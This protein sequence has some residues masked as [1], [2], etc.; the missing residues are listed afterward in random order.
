MSIRSSYLNNT[1]KPLIFSP[2]VCNF[3]LPISS[4]VY[5]T[6]NGSKIP[7][8]FVEV[9]KRLNIAYIP[10]CWILWVSKPDV[11]VEGIQNRLSNVCLQRILRYFGPLTAKMRTQAWRNSWSLIMWKARETLKD[12]RSD[13][14]SQDFG[15]SFVGVHSFP[16]SARPRGVLFTRN[17]GMG[18]KIL[19][20]G[21][22]RVI[23]Y[24]YYWFMSRQHSVDALC[25]FLFQ[26]NNRFTWNMYKNI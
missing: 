2:V 22:R 1:C 8:V 20:N 4:D 14:M 6:K 26:L 25:Q 12:H 18:V 17:I 16:S 10:I 19:R 3:F 5:A 11:C 9:T 15:T 7:G 21:E 23:Y 24:Y 13:Q